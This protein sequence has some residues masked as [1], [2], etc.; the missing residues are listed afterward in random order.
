[1]AQ[2]PQWTMTTLL[3]RIHDHTHTHRTW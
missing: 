2:H 3:L 1:M